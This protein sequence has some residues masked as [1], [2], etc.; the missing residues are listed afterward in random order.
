MP[1]LRQNLATKEWVVIATERARRPEDFHKDRPARAPLPERLDSCP[2]CPGNEARTGDSV[3][4]LGEPWRVRAVRNKF[5]A[6]T[7]EARLD[8]GEAGPYLR[9][10][11]QGVHEVIIESPS[12]AKHL[13][14]LEPEQVR[15]AFFVYR[16]RFRESWKNPSVCTSLVFKNHGASAGTSLEHPHAQLIGSPV[17][18]AHLRHRVDQAEAYLRKHGACVFCDM[19]KEEL[20]QGARI[21]ADTEHFTAFVLF[22]AL[23]PFHIWVLPKRHA[24]SFGEATDAELADLSAVMRVLL[25]KLH[26]GLD[27]PDFNFLIQSVPQDRGH[28][29]S[30]HW[31]LSLVVRVSQMAGFELG[32]GMFINTTLPE[33]S[34]RFLNSVQA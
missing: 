10:A 12:H 30:F 19:R 15:E 2:F 6:L 26:V 24:A 34:A 33:E 28:A 21:L 4:A 16:E 31:Y 23:S 14:L 18:P 22:A 20:R 11:G 13:A 17:V 29:G 3:Y 7:P 32:S 1:E 9:R 25:R 5:P 8:P 27:N